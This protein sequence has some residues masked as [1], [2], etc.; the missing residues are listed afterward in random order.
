M[1]VL[2]IR[3]GHWKAHPSLDSTGWVIFFICGLVTIIPPLQM[4]T[5]MT[6]LWWGLDA[7]VQGKVQQYM[8]LCHT[9]RSPVRHSNIWMPG[10][11]PYRFWQRG[12]REK[13]LGATVRST[14]LCY[15][16]LSHSLEEPPPPHLKTRTWGRAHA[17]M[18]ALQHPADPVSLKA[19]PPH[20]TGCWE[21][22]F[23]LFSEHLIAG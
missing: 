10:P 3:V 1:H 8:V 20:H 15:F 6:V 13:H 18:K 11:H 19:G 17:P 7:T 12:Q 2:F 9:S 16:T 4:R 21:G 14:W 5:P 22:N 23:S